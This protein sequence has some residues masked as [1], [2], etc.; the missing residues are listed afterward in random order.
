MF[1][2]YLKIALRNLARHKGYAFINI[3]GLAVGIAASVL[4]VLFVID[5][6][7]FDRFHAKSGRIY[8]IAAD[9]S[10][11]GD[12]KIHQLGTPW[13]LANTIR[14]KYPQVEALTQITGPLGD[15]VLWKG[16]LALK[17]TEVFAADASFFDVFSFPLVKGDSRTALRDRNAVVLSESLAAKCFGKEDPLEKTIELQVLGRR[18]AQ[19]VTGIMRDV[20]RNSH[21]RFE[22]LVSMATLYP[23]PSTG[24]TNN[25]YITYLL[26]GPG[27]TQAQMEEKLVEIDKVFFEGG[28]PH[29]PWIWTLE[30]ITRIHL[31]SD[32]AT[33]NQPNGSIAYVRLFT[34]VAVL[35][36]VIAGI[37]FVNLATARSARRAREVGIR[38]VVGSRRGQLVGQF[39]GESILL[40]L[41]ALAVAVGLIVAALPM[42]RDLT[43]RALS[44]FLLLGLGIVP[45]LLGLALVLGALAG[46]YPAFFLSSFKQTEVLKGSPFGGRNRGALTLRNV[47][48]VFQFAVSVLL[49][50]GSMVISRQLDF[51]KNQRLGFDKDNVVAVHNADNLGPGLDAFRD[52]LKQH[53]DIVGVTAVSSLPGWGTPNWGIGVEG[54]QTERPLNMNFMTCDQDFAGVLGIRM[55]DGRFMSRDHPSDT[56]AVVING[57]AK[58]YFGL[59]DPVGRKLRIWWTRKDLTIIG[60]IDDFRFESL[61]RDVRPMGYVLPEAIDSTR[62]PYLLAKVRSARTTEVLS[63]IERSWAAVAAGLPFEFTFLDDRIDALYQ[64]DNRAGKIVSVFSAL[65]IFVSCLGLFG[66]A[67]FVTEQRTKEVGIRKIL[68]ARLSSVLWLHTGRFVKWVVAANLIAWPAAYWIMGRWLQGFAFRTPLEARIFLLSG[69]YAL[70]IALLTVS[71]QVVRAARANPADAL[72]YE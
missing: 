1:K 48:V 30:P 16:D 12:S 33:G 7:G 62:K 69:L 63:H 57:K 59:S 39:L 28:R 50:T 21:F 66:L 45:A 29:Q 5:E 61:H 14:E 23:T 35:I 54:V 72:R 67:A 44:P 3:L 9:W 60:V 20:P 27:V 37:N 22:M 70:A 42:Y 26:L 17:E 25:N 56:D 13:I 46:L 32:L 64:N 65:A 40:S 34:L 52:R 51:I 11:K 18:T 58:E 24:W 38:K 47:L 68:G 31:Y 55:A 4:V 15:V 49:I 53:P 10:N 36:L 43:G 71:F 6:L 19:R 2:S 41:V 8:R